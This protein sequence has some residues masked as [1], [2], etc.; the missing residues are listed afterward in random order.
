[1]V[2]GSMTRFHSLWCKSRAEGA[3]PEMQ[4]FAELCAD[5]FMPRRA[6]RQII[7]GRREPKYL[8]LERAWFG[9]SDAPDRPSWP[10][11]WQAVSAR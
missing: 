3:G 8:E 10:S 4:G 9:L 7:G 1:M 6:A 11:R 2:N 5:E